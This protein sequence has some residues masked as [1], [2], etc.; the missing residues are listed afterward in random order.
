MKATRGYA[1]ADTLSQVD[2]PAGYSQLDNESLNTVGWASMNVTGNLTAPRLKSRAMTKPKQGQPKAPDNVIRN[3]VTLIKA[4]RG[5]TNNRQIIALLG[6]DSSLFYRRQDQG[7]LDPKKDL[8]FIQRIAEESG[9]PQEA[10][11]PI[12][13]NGKRRRES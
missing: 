6:I 12:L 5:L 13:G 8:Y 9:M 1:S 2:R 11:T 3:A 10:F 4:R 7:W